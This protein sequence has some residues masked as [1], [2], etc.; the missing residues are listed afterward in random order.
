MTALKSMQKPVVCNGPKT[1][2]ANST[3]A[4]KDFYDPSQLCPTL[5]DNEILVPLNSFMKIV[6]LWNYSLELL[7][8]YF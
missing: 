7:P 3:L 5:F 8:V 4:K 6:L 1:Q 2:H